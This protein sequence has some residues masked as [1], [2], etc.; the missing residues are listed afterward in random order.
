MERI[1]MKRVILGGLLAGLI[2]DISEF[3]LNMHVL[4]EQHA[5]AMKALGR[6]AEVT[7]GQIVFFNAWCFIAGI[8]AVWL[9][10]AIRPRFGPGPRTALLAGA[11]FWGLCYVLGSA[12]YAAMGLFPTN[13]ILIGWVW[14][15]CEVLL[16]TFLGARIYNE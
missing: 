13:L 5:E 11:I 12:C 6:S 9:Y 10:A 16:G 4:G 8:A 14:G 2:I 7:T 3:I 15:L 1:N